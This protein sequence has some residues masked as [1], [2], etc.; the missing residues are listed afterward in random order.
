MSQ[1]KCPLPVFCIVS[2]FQYT[3]RTGLVVLQDDCTEKAAKKGEYRKAD[4]RV[5]LS[6]PM[7]G[8][9][10]KVANSLP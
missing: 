6:W 7:Q 9:I 5:R 2:H 1:V 3:L 10:V 8:N 4:T